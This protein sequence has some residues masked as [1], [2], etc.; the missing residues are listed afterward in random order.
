M[1]E[2]LV[3]VGLVATIV[4]FLDYG[5]KI[6]SHLSEFPSQ[7]KDIPKTFRDLKT[8][9]P[10]LLKPFD[11]TKQQA[12]AGTI[13]MDTQ[14]VLLPVVGSCHKQVEELESILA[15]ALLRNKTNLDKFERKRL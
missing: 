11:K 13:D 8:E 12:Q 15:K 14:V 4:S 6:V 3:A 2:V 5:E 7:T 10:L 9:L 1:A